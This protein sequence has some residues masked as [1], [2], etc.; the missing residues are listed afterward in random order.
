[1]LKKN[2]KSF[3]L[4]FIVLMTLSFCFKNKIKYNVIYFNSKK[5]IFYRLK[6]DF[7]IVKFTSSSLIDCKE[8]YLYELKNNKILFKKQSTYKY[9]YKIKSEQLT[10]YN[11]ILF[12]FKDLKD[13]VFFPDSVFVVRNNLKN[14]IEKEKNIFELENDFEY[15]KIYYKEK[16]II[17]SKDE[18][19]EIKLNIIYIELDNFYFIED[20]VKV[21]HLKIN[22]FKYF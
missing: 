17:I 16:N 9:N 11:K 22:K 6:N 1:M 4:F 12:E 8:Y 15:I 21:K 13:S 20:F 19:S 10:N 5:N 18:F 2:I 3:S 7:I 14:K